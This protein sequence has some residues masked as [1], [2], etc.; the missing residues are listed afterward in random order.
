MTF[1]N[2]ARFLAYFFR[3]IDLPFCVMCPIHSL[4]CESVSENVFFGS[5]DCPVRGLSRRN[6][7]IIAY[8]PP[9]RFSKGS[10]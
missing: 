5:Y 7:G 8:L 10:T 6:S 3:S 4:P 9:H 1:L 2:L